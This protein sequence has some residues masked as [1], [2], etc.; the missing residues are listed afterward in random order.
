MKLV[1]KLIIFI[2]LS[3][4]ESL[5]LTPYLP[6]YATDF[7][8]TL[9]HFDD[10][11][12]R[13]LH[14]ARRGS[15]FG[16]TS[17]AAMI[18]KDKQ[19]FTNEYRINLISTLLCVGVVSIDIGKQ[20]RI[21]TLPFENSILR[22]VVWKKYIRNTK[23]EAKT[24]AFLTEYF[25]GRDPS[26]RMCEELL[27]QQK[28]TNDLVGLKNNL[29]DLRILDITYNTDELRPELFIY[30][31]RLTTITGAPKQQV[32]KFD[33]VIEL[34]RS[35]ERW[36]SK[37]KPSSGKLASMVAFLA[38]VMR[39]YSRNISKHAKVPP[40]VRAK[41]DPDQLHK[42]GIEWVPPVGDEVEKYQIQSDADYIF[43][44]WLW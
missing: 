8:E 1:R 17:A 40:F 34:N 19:S 14:G 13:F 36:Y 6:N 30:L 43:H 39:W 31:Q 38:D 44:R 18:L 3:N 37:H 2:G 5:V 27:W 11:A 33:I 28:K 23:G 41:L 32:G 20:G 26:L 15:V 29:L 7:M 22:D 21:L 42:L 25:H 4:L 35:V 12:R 9:D 16:T 24:R 10:L